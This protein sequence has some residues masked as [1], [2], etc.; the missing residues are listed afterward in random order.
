VTPLATNQVQNKSVIKPSNPFLKKSSSVVSSPVKRKAIDN[1]KDL[2]GSPSPKK[3]A[4]NRQ[5]SFSQHARIN[6]VKDKRLL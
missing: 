3:P 4:L 1:I 2:K 5:S 6:A